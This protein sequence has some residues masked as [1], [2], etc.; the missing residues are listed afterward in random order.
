MDYFAQTLQII[1]GILSN[2]MYWVALFATILLT[3]PIGLI[4]GVGATTVLVIA[5]P[6]VILNLDP[7]IGLVFIAGMLSLGNTMDIIPAVLLGYPSGATAVDF[8]EGHQLARR[9]LGARV[10]GA[11]YAVS[12]IGGLIGATTPGVRDAR[13]LRAFIVNFSYAE[14]AAMALF[15][16]SMVAILSRGA[17]MKGLGSASWAYFLRASACCPLAASTDSR[18]TTSTSGMAYRWWRSS[19]ECSRSRSLWTSA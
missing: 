9:G 5:L 7:L 17:V 13:A 16:V 1:G 18:S 6:F 2:P 8:L 11:S 10:L 4:P 19:W 3:G 14:I 15:G 12:M